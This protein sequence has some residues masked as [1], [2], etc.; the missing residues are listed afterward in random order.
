MNLDSYIYVFFVLQFN[1]EYFFKES[2]IGLFIRNYD[3]SI[4]NLV[5]IGNKINI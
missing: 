5:N 2:N 1:N 3:Y 4:L